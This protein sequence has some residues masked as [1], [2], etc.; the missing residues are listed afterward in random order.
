MGYGETI[1]PKSRYP[2][3]KE[4]ALTIDYSGWALVTHKWLPASVAYAAVETI[5]QRQNL[6]P[7][8]DDQPL[9][10]SNLCHG[11]DKCPLQVPLHPGAAKYYR[12][13]GYLE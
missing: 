10:M 12:E 11:T 5:D 2:Q 13:K 1:L 9:N 7:V 6:I 4:D 8:D 3:L